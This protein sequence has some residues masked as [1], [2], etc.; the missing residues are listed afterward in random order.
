MQ[1]CIQIKKNQLEEEAI[2]IIFLWDFRSRCNSR[3]NI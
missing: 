2:G 3:C 1:T